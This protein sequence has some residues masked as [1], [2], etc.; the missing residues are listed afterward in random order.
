MALKVSNKN[1]KKVHQ[2]KIE[3]VQQEHTEFTKKF[4]R[5]YVAAF[6]ILTIII[7]IL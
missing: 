4:T 7:F 3:K 1:R 5:Y 6:I 2:E